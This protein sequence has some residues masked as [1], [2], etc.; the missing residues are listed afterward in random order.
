MKKK[1]I[2]KKPVRELSLQT[3]REVVGGLAGNREDAEK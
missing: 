2:V 1:K 3:V